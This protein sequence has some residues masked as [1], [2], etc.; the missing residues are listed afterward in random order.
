MHT[1]S[2]RNRHDNLRPVVWLQSRLLDDALA[3]PA[4]DPATENGLVGA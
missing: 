4:G 3:L 1:M 2:W